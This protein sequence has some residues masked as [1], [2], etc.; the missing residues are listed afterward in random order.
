MGC[1]GSIFSRRGR[2]N[3]GNSRKGKTKGNTGGQTTSSSDV[4]TNGMNNTAGKTGTTTTTTDSETNG[5][6]SGYDTKRVHVQQQDL[7]PGEEKKLNKEI[8]QKLMLDEQRENRTIGLLLLGA[9]GSGK[10]TV[11]KQ[12]EKIY[13][14]HIAQNAL[15]DAVHYIRQ[16]YTYIHVYV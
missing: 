11:L 16:V 12:M 2:N 3:N 13:K 1:A 6:T 9:G 7:A 4:A 8:E 10:S 15:D 5:L 14:G